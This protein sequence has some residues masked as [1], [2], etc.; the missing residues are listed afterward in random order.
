[1]AVRWTRAI[2]ARGAL[3]LL[4]LACDPRAHAAD[5][6]P[7]PAAPA[8]SASATAAAVQAA[9]ASAPAAGTINGAPW[10]VHEASIRSTS[11]KDELEIDLYPAHPASAEAAAVMARVLIGA[12]RKTGSFAIGAEAACTMVAPP[13]R[14]LVATTGTIVIDSLDGAHAIGHLDCADGAGSTVR[15]RF[16]AT[17]DAGADAGQA[18]R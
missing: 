5:A 17:I 10:T 12:P 2:C 7:A 11:T 14:N 9:D 8:G 15:G 1:M 13:S 18:A 3:A 6:S 16:A 4:A